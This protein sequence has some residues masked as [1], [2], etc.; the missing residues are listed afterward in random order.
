M[1]LERVEFLLGK[2]CAKV[3][4]FAD[5]V[6]TELK[7]SSDCFMSLE[8]VAFELIVTRDRVRQIEANALKKLYHDWVKKGLVNEF[9]EFLR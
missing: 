5:E 8:E 1:N 9:R 6:T 4:P 3:A 7:G 2:D